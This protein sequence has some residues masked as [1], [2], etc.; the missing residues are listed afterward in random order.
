MSSNSIQPSAELSLICLILKVFLETASSD[1]LARH[2]AETPPNSEMLMNLLKI[3]RVIP[4]VYLTLKQSDLLDKLPTALQDELI[5]QYHQLTRRSLQLTAE[6][7]RLLEQFQQAGIRVLPL[8]GTL[9]SQQVYGSFIHRAPGDIDLLVEPGTHDAAVALLETLGYRWSLADESWSQ[10]QKRLYVQQQGEVTYGNFS[11]NISIDLHVRWTR[12]HRFFTLSFDEAWQQAAKL[13]ISEMTELCVLCPAHQMLFLSAHAAKHRWDRLAWL[14]D[15]ARLLKSIDAT[16]L[17][18]GRAAAQSLCIQRPLEQALQLS[19][20]W[21]NFT[22]PSDSH[23]QPQA[24]VQ[25]LA[26]VASGKILDTRPRSTVGQFNTPAITPHAVWQSLK[27]E[28]QLKSDF[29]YRQNCLT[30]FSFSARD[31]QV[32]QLPEQLWFL[33]ILLRPLFYVWRLQK[34]SKA[35]NP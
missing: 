15:V 16:D 29:A 13:K 1:E 10:T 33:Y 31:W 12:N 17:K 3:H 21:L 27:Y 9:L 28:L 4:V 8:K 14:L 23:R 19:R 6:T 11:N 35:F 7:I 20:Q 18:H 25:W 34:T 32:L 30:R 22:I 5:R 2:L 26:R 24:V